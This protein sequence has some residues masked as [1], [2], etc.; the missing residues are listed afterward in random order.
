MKFIKVLSQLSIKVKGSGGHF[1][2]IETLLIKY[3]KIE[4]CIL[5]QHCH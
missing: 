5:T 3:L 2:L 1:I 4:A